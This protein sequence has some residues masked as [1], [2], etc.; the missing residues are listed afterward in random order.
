M[1]LAPKSAKAARLRRIHP[2]SATC[3]ADQI[4]SLSGHHVGQL[5]SRRYCS[6]M[7]PLVDMGAFVVSLREIRK[8]VVVGRSGSNWALGNQDFHCGLGRAPEALLRMKGR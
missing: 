1:V 7:C 2:L 3:I 5:R 4:H 6:G 8:G